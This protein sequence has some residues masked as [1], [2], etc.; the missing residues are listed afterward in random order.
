MSGWGAWSASVRPW[1]SAS[2]SCDL[3]DGLAHL[4][5]LGRKGRIADE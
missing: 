1:K 4:F 5:T 2:R 3:H